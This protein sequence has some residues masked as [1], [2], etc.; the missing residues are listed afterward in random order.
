MAQ[1]IYLDYAATTP[2]AP[3]VAKTMAGCL[4]LEGN[5]ANPASRTHVYGWQAEEAVEIARGQ[6][7]ALLNADAREIIWTSGATESNNLALKGV[8]EPLAHAGHL[9]VS[10]V[11][12]KAVLDPAIWLKEQGVD[13]SFLQPNSIG[14]ISAEQ[15]K[16]AMRDDTALVS[17]MLVNNELGSINPIEEIA[18][19]CR[20]HRCLLHVDAAQAVGKIPVDVKQL[21]VDLLSVSAHKMYGP[22]G[23]GA[24]YVKRHGAVKVAAQIHGGGHERGMRSGTLA[25][26]QCAGFGSAA[27]IALQ[28][29]SHDN[30]HVLALRNKLWAGISGL[31]GVSIN[32]SLQASVAG[33]LNVTF[34]GIDGEALLLSLRELAV[35]TG[36]ACTSATMSPS[37]V[38]KAIGLNDTDALSSV[39]F[40]LGRYTTDDEIN[41]AITHIC[42]VVMH[43]HKQHSR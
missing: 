6:V 18:S 42:S 15:V 16:Q 20:K 17:I 4:T 12:H 43:I 37:Y 10:A 27:Q 36:S 21:D 22:K 34:S 39:R 31:P 13:V 11:E 23:I 26:H 29:M 32:G 14:Q 35:S 5:F 40:S 38:L 2:V 28:E 8:F 25:T 1:P 7:A 9:I 3:E 24:L 19:I 30:K 33:H 41:R